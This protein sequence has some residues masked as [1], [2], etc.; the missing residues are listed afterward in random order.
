MR[1][2]SASI[3][4]VLIWIAAAILA[5]QTGCAT[6]RQPGSY[7][8]APIDYFSRSAPPVPTMAVRQG[9]GTIAIAPAQYAPDSNFAAFAEGPLAGAVKG[10][11]TYGGLT[12]FAGAAA[13]ALTPGAA[14]IAPVAVIL[15]TINA[16]ANAAA[17]GVLGAMEAE[18]TGKAQEFRSVIADAVARLYAQNALAARL[19][20]EVQ[21][22]ARENL[23]AAEAAGPTAPDE[24][25]GYAQLRGAGIDTVLEVAIAEIGFGGCGKGFLAK[26]CAGGSDKSLVYLFMIGRLRLVRVV[27]GAELYAN[28]FRYDS[29]PRELAHWAANNAQALAK[30]FERGYQDLAER[31][32]DEL[33]M[34]TPIELP[35]PSYW[36]LPGDPL[37]LTCWLC[38]ISPAVD[39]RLFDAKGLREHMMRDFKWFPCVNSPILFT[40]VD[41]VRPLLQWS[42]FPRDLDRKELDPALLAGIRDVTYEVR[43]WEVDECTRG[44]LVYQRAGLD[45]PRHQLD[46]ALDPATRY[47]WSFRARFSFDGR[48]MTTRWAFYRYGSCDRELIPE[49]IYYRFV[50]PDPVDIT[51]SSAGMT[52]S[53]LSCGWYAHRSPF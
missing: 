24:C 18:S 1:H 5:V 23:S 41:S 37:Y 53:S 25:P 38:P 36:L 46:R 45:E 11:A 26:K 51:P 13:F 20:S 6:S 39:L 31:M 43:I 21:K 48:M 30:A 52:P 14:A 28:E 15:V 3:K 16:A 4:L 50:T 12:L 7:E 29:P 22:E 44:K 40:A 33:L 8:Y 47:Y 19:A 32:H 42:K 49:E 2:R 9:I 10:G 27:D 17:G 34:V 35:V